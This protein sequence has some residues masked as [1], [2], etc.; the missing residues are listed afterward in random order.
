[1]G[2]EQ[3]PVLDFED[4]DTDVEAQIT[5]LPPPALVQLD[6]P[7]MYGATVDRSAIGE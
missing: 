5:S 3:T 1:M 2:L 6:P 4:I 7:R